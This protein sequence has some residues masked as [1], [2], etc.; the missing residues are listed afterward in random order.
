MSAKRADA[1]IKTVVMTGGGNDIIQVPGLRDDCAAN[2][3]QCAMVLSEILD[4]LTQLWTEMAM[5]GVQDVVYV[6]YSN[7][8]GNNVDYALPSGDGVAKRCAEVPTPLRCHPLETLDIVMGDIPDGIHPSSAAFDRLGTA[9]HDLMTTQGMRRK[10]RSRKRLL[11]DTQENQ[12]DRVPQ[13]DDDAWRARE[14]GP[15]SAYLHSAHARS[16]IRAS[17]PSALAG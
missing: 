4:R 5:D 6:Q 14:C 8:E 1:D 10:V 15:A 16:R 13:P 3:A 7:P 2:G 11:T 9:V 12:P 17:A